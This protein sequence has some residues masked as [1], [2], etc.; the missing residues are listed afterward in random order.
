[1]PNPHVVVAFGST[2]QLAGLDLTRAPEVEPNLPDGQNVEF[3][4]RTGSRALT[5]RVHERG[6]G[7]TRSCGTGICAAVVATA[8]ADRT[9]PDAPLVGDDTTWQVDVPGGRCWVTWSSTGE[10][11][12]C[13]PA[14]LV[15]EI[16]LSD[17]WLA[18]A[19]GEASAY[20]QVSAG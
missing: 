5:M 19:Q 14:V 10:I 7:E 12:L 18:R 8:L 16:E 1:M 9:E 6:V 3:V 20:S 2:H 15:A 4:V 13:G 17:E 11:E